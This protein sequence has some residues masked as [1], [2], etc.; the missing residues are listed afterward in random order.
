MRYCLN[1]TPDNAICDVENGVCY[2]TFPTFASAQAYIDNY[3][4]IEDDYTIVLLPDHLT[5]Y[6]PE[7]EYTEIGRFEMGCDGSDQYFLV[8]GKTDIIPEDLLEDVE[9]KFYVE[10]YKEAGGYFCKQFDLMKQSNSEYVVRVCH[11]Y[12]V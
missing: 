3:S 7:Y 10:T 4:G 1:Y 9:H 11:R 6:S 2:N 5:A 12:D 8:R